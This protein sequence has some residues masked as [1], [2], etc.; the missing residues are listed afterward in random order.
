MSKSIE[1]LK[2]GIQSV[3]QSDDYGRKIETDTEVSFRGKP[4]PEVS[5]VKSN[6]EVSDLNSVV[7]KINSMDINQKREVSIEAVHYGDR[8]ISDVKLTTGDIV[9]VE[10]AIALAGN[11]MLAG[12]S[13]GKTV[14]G[15]RVLRS[16]PDPKNSEYHGIYSLPEF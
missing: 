15:G 3:Q 12:Y 7:S 10:E 13:T 2:N 14:R 11:H 1:I 9:S 5:K 8:G 4:I 16:K 6:F